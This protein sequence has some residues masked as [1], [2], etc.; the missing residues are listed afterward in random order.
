VAVR[1]LLL[2]LT[3][4]ALLDLVEALEERDG[5]EDDNGLSA[6]TNLDLKE[7]WC[8]RMI[9]RPVPTASSID[10]AIGRMC[11]SAHAR[12]FCIEPSDFAPEIFHSF[13]HNL[14]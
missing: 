9:R 6:V 7:S 1:E 3:G 8:Q 2:E 4:Q 14:G 13:F 12:L 11:V 5:D 10:Q